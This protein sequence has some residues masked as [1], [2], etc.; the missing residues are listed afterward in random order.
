M[1]DLFSSQSD[2]YAAFRP[3]YPQALFDHILQFVPGRENAWDCGTGNGQ[4]AVKLAAY[5]QQVYAT[6][7]SGNQLQEAQAHPRIEFKQESAEAT[8]AADNRFDLITVAQAIHWFDF[9][10]FYTEVRRTA[11]PNAILAVLGYGLLQINPALDAVIAELYTAMLGTYWDPERRYIDE[12]YQTIP[13]PFPEIEPVAFA[14]AIDWTFEHLTG[15]LRTWSAVKHYQKAWA[16]DPVALI[17]G[18]LQEAWGKEILHTIRF[19]I[20][21][22][23]GRVR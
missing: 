22:R 13:F 1:K 15:Y 8:T 20:L 4:V 3:D 11:K 18:K 9:D 6:D 23:L 5:F 17:S 19:P 10:A 14:H 16:E 21:S 7:I 2:Q 12:H